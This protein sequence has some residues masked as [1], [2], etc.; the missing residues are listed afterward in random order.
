MKLEDLVGEYITT[1]IA[2]KVAEAELVAIKRENEF[3]RRL[4]TDNQLRQSD[5]GDLFCEHC[6]KRKRLKGDGTSE[7]LCM[8]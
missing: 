4:V 1:G 2:L 5:K 3:L 8:C 7:Q 6:G